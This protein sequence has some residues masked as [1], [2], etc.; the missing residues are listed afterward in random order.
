MARYGY[1]RLSKDRSL[2]AINVTIQRNE[3]DDYALDTGVAIKQHF[4]DND[5]TASEFGTRPRDDYISLI[6]TLMRST[7][8][9]D[10][11][12]VTEIPRLTRQSEEGNELL[13]LSKTKPLRYVSTTDGMRYD[14]RTPRGRKSFREAVSDAEFE[15]D[16]SSSRQHKKKNNLASAGAFHGGQRPYGY[17]GAR[18]EQLVDEHGN[19]YK[20][21]ILNPGR[22]GTAIIDEE[23][24]VRREATQRIIS[25]EREIDLVR[26]FNARGITNGSGGKWRIGNLKSWLMRKRD[27]A[28]DVFPGKGTRIHKGAEYR[29]IWDAIISKEDYE[30]MATAF[31]MRSHGKRS[32]YID[33]RQYLLSGIARS[34]H[35]GEALYGRYKI[36]KDGSHVRRYI[37]VPQNVHGEKNEGPKIARLADPVDLYVVEAVIEAFNTPEVAAML[38]P[39]E[40]GDRIKELVQL[41][42][43]QQLHLQQLIEDYGE[44][45][46]T[47]D[48]LV[49]AKRSA[50]DVL[51]KTESELAKIQS[52]KTLGLIPASQNLR[53]FMETASIAQK[54]KVILLVVDH[55]V[56][57]SGHPR[58]QKWRG[59]HFNPDDVEIVWRR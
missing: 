11:I 38:A 25:G 48:E 33:G 32:G 49:T 46:L 12:I 9:E 35:S 54:R 1:E 59:Y 10:E 20:G 18:Y 13:Q 56:I 36:R 5:K 14:L 19:T 55:V 7:D 8:D 22:V 37:S 29:A 16:Q 34:G 58:G 47:R 6:A 31:R 4:C 41:R 40:N 17:E 2:R 39:A 57:K 44:G 50:Q 27:V 24:A 53:D 23:A 21:R 45:I 26:D 28:F 30:L 52:T 42:A 15:S 43:K 3:I 51:S